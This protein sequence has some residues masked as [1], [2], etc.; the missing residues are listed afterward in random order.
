L[1]LPIGPGDPSGARGGRGPHMSGP[2][3]LQR[4]K[5]RA[6]RDNRPRARAGTGSVSY[7]ALNSVFSASGAGVIPTKQKTHSR[8]SPGAICRP[9]RICSPR[10]SKKALARAVS[11]STMADRFSASIADRAGSS[12]LRECR[13]PYVATE[14]LALSARSAL[15]D[16]K[17]PGTRCVRGM[18][19]KS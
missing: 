18:C 11:A 13:D 17:G 4:G 15:A 3:Y 7:Q 1:P 14:C 9:G 19:S 5:R 2:C 10:R 16:Q 6:L 8:R 12:T